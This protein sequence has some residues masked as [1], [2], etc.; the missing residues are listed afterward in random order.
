LVPRRQSMD[1]IAFTLVVAAA[2][3][4]PAAMAAGG[5]AR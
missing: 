1:R 3:F 4:A 5:K 2:I